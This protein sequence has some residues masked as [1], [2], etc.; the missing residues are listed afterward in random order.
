MEL[1][2]HIP[3][4]VRKCTYCTFI[5]FPGCSVQ[6]KSKYLDALLHEARLRKEEITEPVSTVYIGGGT[7]S[8]IP[9][10]L[11]A[12]FLSELQ[13]IIDLSNVCEFTVEANPG[14]LTSSWLKTVRSFGVNRLSLG[15][16]AYSPRLL[17]LLGRIHTMS[18][19]IESVHIARDTGF[20]NLNLDLI[21]GI[22]SQ[23]MHDW[24]NTISAALSLHPEHISAYGLIPEENTLLQQRIESGE[25]TLP[26]PELEREMY[27]QAICR[28]QDAGLQQYEISNFSRKGYECRHNIGYWSQVPYL[29]LGISAASMR[30]TFA[31]TEVFSIRHSNPNS[32]AAYYRMLDDSSFSCGETENIT[33][34]DARFETVMLSLRMTKGLNRDHFRLLHGDFPETFFGDTLRN[35]EKNGLLVFRNHAWCLTRRGMD[36]QNAVLLEFMD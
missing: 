19:V 25:L 3:F 32:F 5:S 11:M 26:D 23:T 7:P 2:I 20:D 31:S 29:G 34:K 4:C 6:D 8:L 22:P 12:S 35:L 27:D 28:F 10:D 9:P 24:Q 16:Q 14:T 18:D 21:F 33:Y 17:T 15:M 1:Y 30:L 13:S 36:I